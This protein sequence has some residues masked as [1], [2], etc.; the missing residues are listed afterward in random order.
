MKP[1]EY[2]C[3]VKGEV[4]CPRPEI[5]SILASNMESGQNTVVVGERGF[6]SR[7]PRRSRC[8]RKA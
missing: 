8:R 4:F 2:G 6:S 3:I 1:F 5:E 7:S